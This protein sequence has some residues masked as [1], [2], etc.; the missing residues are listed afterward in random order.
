LVIGADGFHCGWKNK[1]VAINYR[2]RT[3]AE[4]DLMSVEVTTP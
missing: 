2:E 4:G 3:P 1:P